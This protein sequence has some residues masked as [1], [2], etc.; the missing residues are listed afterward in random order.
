VPGDYK[1]EPIEFRR[2]PLSA[3]A[4]QMRLNLFLLNF[5]HHLFFSL[6]LFFWPQLSYSTLCFLLF[7]TVHA[8][9]TLPVPTLPS[10][11][12]ICI[13]LLPIL[14]HRNLSSA[15]AGR[16]TMRNYSGLI[17]SLMAYVQ[18]CVAAS[19]CDDK[20]RVQVPGD[21][22][23]PDPV[24]CAY[25]YKSQGHALKSGTLLVLTFLSQNP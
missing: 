1:T 3:R 24:V 18:N 19:R 25:S 15:D 8:H 13:L 11:H 16:Q 17:D 23:I 5:F 2:R 14:S 7:F 9:C 20:V 6:P 22:S 10:H 4:R 12:P 21:T